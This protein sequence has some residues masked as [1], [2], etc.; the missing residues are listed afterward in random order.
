[1]TSSIAATFSRKSLEAIKAREEHVAAFIEFDAALPTVLTTAW[2]K[3]C[4]RWEAD[5]S[6][7]NPFSRSHQGNDLRFV[8]LFFINIDQQSCPRWTF[9]F[10]WLKKT[11]NNWPRGIKSHYM[12]MSHP[13]CLYF[14][15]WN[16]KNFSELSISFGVP[17]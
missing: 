13:V 2:T 15:V 1:L 7:E 5:R 3:L 12:M 16:L 8:P 10:D 17:I 14:K 4:W 6:Q 9:D 11:Q